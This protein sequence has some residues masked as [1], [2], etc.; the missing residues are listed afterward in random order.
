MEARL[1]KLYH[2]YVG[3]RC[4][5][6]NGSSS[7][8]MALPLHAE[9]AEAEFALLLAER[10]QNNPISPTRLR[11][12]VAKGVPAHLRGESWMAFSGA[13]DLMLKNQGLFSK[14]L[15]VAARPLSPS[16]SS[17]RDHT[18]IETDLRRSGSE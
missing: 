6:S 14:L 12:A 5:L 1:N 2:Y 16:R 3:P 10:K 7:S 17:T 13:R 9:T 4:R 15:T 18:Q 11:A 8:K